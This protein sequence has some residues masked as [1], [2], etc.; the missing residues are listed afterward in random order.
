L[1]DT[2]VVFHVINDAGADVFIDNRQPLVLELHGEFVRLDPGCGSACPSCACK[3]CPA[4]PPQ[5][6][7]IPDAGSWDEGW[8]R[9][10]YVSQRCGGA[11]PCT[12]EV[13]AKPG[14][15]TVILHGK[16]RANAARANQSLV[17]NGRLDEGSGDCQATA[18]FKLSRGARVDLKLACD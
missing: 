9:R 7:R 8:N 6:R 16:R 2:D 10:V 5:V 1:S 4:E 15:Y 3:E 14:S 18:S 17:F 13:D 11:C 12:R